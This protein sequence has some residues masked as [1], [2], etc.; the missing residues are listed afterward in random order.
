MDPATI[1]GLCLAITRNAVAFITGISDIR[2]NY[3]EAG[4]NV[5]NLRRQTDLLRL[6]AD[7]IQAWMNRPGARLSE[8]EQRIFNDSVQACRM[9]VEMLRQA[10]DATLGVRNDGQERI[11][12][13][14]R[15]RF[16]WE[17]ARLDRYLVTEQSNHK[18]QFLTANSQSVSINSPD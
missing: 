12:R 14:R 11:A 5:R 16:L 8:E 1:A 3:R 7:R 2:S 13:W 18:F 9:Y 6:A 10:A 17:Q 15:V 4:L